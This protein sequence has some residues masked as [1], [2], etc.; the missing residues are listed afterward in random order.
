MYKII[1]NIKILGK[2]PN[3]LPS[4]RK[5]KYWI[6]SILPILTHNIHINVVIVSRSIIY[7]LNKKYRNLSTVTNVLVFPFVFTTQAIIPIIG[8]IVI[9]WQVVEYESIKLNKK[10]EIYYSHMLIHGLLHLLNYKHNSKKNSIIMMNLEKSI[11]NKIK[12]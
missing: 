6:S 4:N 8:D 12:Y 2:K 9:C 11:L 10:L 3:I 1:S 5:F 7:F